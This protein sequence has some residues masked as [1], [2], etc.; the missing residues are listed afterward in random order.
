[1]QPL[2]SQQYSQSPTVTPSWQ[3]LSQGYDTPESTVDTLHKDI[4]D[5]I[6]SSK[7]DFGKNPWDSSIQTRL[8]AL[9][10]LQTILSSQQLPPNQIALIRTQVAQL[11]EAAQSSVPP[12][13]PPQP[14]TPLAPIAAAQPPT[15]QSTLSSVLGPGALAA[16]LARQSG[17]PPPPPTQ[18]SAS[19][20]PPPSVQPAFSAPMATPSVSTPLPN[21]SSLLER[22]RAAGILQ[23]GT[24]AT[25][26]PTLTHNSL[27]GKISQGFPPP[28][29][30]TPPDTSRMP[31]AETPN[32]VVLKAASLKL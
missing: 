6:A 32:D 29:I 1:M 9:L 23:S 15:Q 5:L 2:P 16:L 17:I 31:L 25:S 24:P 8:K 7:A 28:F 12:V 18:S 21:P 13:A 27:A 20:S 4:S 26:T 10:D 22:L 30:N 11:S 14:T 3:P 19:R